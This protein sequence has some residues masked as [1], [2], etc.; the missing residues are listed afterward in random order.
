MPVQPGDPA[1]DLAAVDFEGN[2]WRLSDRRGKAVVLLFH[3]HA[4]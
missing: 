3:R 2:P 1:P 4:A